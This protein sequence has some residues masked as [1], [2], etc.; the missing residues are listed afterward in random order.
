M[1]ARMRTMKVR[2]RKAITARMRTMKIRRRK[3]RK[4]KSGEV[5]AHSSKMPLLTFRMAL[6]T[7]WKRRRRRCRPQWKRKWR[8]WFAMLK[9]I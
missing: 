5:F 6:P 1:T 4:M 8:R 7:F 9:T 2:G 3:A